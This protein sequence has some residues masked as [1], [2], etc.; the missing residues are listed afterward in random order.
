[1]HFRKPAV[2]ER[3]KWEFQKLICALWSETVLSAVL[4][5]ILVFGSTSEFFMAYLSRMKKQWS[6]PENLGRSRLQPHEV[7]LMHTEDRK[8]H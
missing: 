3:T 1:M 7:N 2:S 5:R 4:K 8:I 6:K